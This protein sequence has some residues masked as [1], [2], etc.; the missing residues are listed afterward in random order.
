MLNIMPKA[1]F[2]SFIFTVMAIEC[3][4][5]K[6]TTVR[7]TQAKTWNQSVLFLATV[8]QPEMEQCNRWWLQD[9]Q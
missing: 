8:A 1:T 6:K 7:G 4:S 9:F 2:I 5:K 3:V